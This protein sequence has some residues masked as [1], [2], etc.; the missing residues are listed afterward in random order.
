MKREAVAGVVSELPIGWTFEGLLYILCSSIEESLWH[1]ALWVGLHIFCCLLFRAW[2]GCLQTWFQW[3][4]GCVQNMRGA[5]QN[6]FLFVDKKSW[7][8]IM[9]SV[10]NYNHHLSDSDR[11]KYI[12]RNPNWGR[13]K[14]FRPMI[15]VKLIFFLINRVSW[16]LPFLQN[17]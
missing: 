10:F 3:S 15:F 1:L 6:I 17:I 12:S 2:K 7:E 8:V 16:K 4:L 14:Q 5:V 9:I 13:H 11:E